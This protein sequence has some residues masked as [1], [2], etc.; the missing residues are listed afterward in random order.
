MAIK[1]DKSLQSDEMAEDRRSVEP[2]GAERREHQRFDTSIAVDYASGETFLFAYLQNISEM[3]IFI[4]TDHPAKVG[5]HL[6]LRFHVDAEENPLTLDGVVTWINPLRASGDNLN[7]GMGVRF[8]ELS[9]D[10]REQVVSLV[11]TVAYLNDDA[12]ETDAQA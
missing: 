7:P 10:K 6:R 3:G 12:D 9:P 11:R 2:S 8:M 1:N 4:R 5:T